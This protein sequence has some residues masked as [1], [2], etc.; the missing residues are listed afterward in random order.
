VLCLPKEV[1][2][3][4]VKDLDRAPGSY[5]RSKG[6]TDEGTCQKHMAQTGVREGEQREKGGVGSPVGVGELPQIRHKGSGGNGGRDIGY[7]QMVNSEAAGKKEAG[8]RRIKR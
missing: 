5:S 7:G 1:C 6:E 8:T 4:R 2:S 3:N